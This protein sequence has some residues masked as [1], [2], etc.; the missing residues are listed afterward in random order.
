MPPLEGFVKINVDAGVSVDHN[1]GTVVAICRD[2]DG[3]YL[4]S[5]VLVGNG[6]TEPSALEAPACREVL[7][8]AQDLGM[9]NIQVA[10]DCK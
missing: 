2:R 8:L 6:L 10:P 9:H 5:S 4:G 7:S 1:L 3:S